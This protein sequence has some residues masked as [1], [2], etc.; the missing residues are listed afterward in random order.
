[1]IKNPAIA[2]F[3]QYMADGRPIE[4]SAMDKATAAIEKV[5]EKLVLDGVAGQGAS[6]AF[7]KIQPTGWRAPVVSDSE[8]PLAKRAQSGALFEERSAQ[9]FEKTCQVIRRIFGK[10][11]EQAEEAIESAKQMLAEERGAI[12]AGV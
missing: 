10:N 3:E 8:T 11:V 4:T 7:S 12:I 5:F 2:E 1:M 9:R 6:T